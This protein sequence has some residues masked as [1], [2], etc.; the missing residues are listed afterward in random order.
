MAS[1]QYRSVFT[2]YTDQADGSHAQFQGLHPIRSSCRLVA[3]PEVAE[4]ASIC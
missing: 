3:C 1:C 2:L 4:D